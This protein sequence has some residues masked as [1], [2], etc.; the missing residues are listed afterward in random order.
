MLI[1]VPAS[2]S[3]APQHRL[4]DTGMYCAQPGA[5][6]IARSWNRYVERGFGKGLGSRFQDLEQGG[7]LN[8][9]NAVAGPS[10]AKVMMMTMPQL[11]IALLNI[12][13]LKGRQEIMCLQHS[14]IKCK[15]ASTYWRMHM[16]LQLMGRHNSAFQSQNV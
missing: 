9:G 16:D 1:I 11:L 15:A 2:S 4:F 3:T 10:V 8:C 12:C 7:D 5:F 6:A 13:M 14:S